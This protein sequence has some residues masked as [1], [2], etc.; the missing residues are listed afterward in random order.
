MTSNGL[1]RRR[2]LAVQMGDHAVNGGVVP[3]VALVTNIHPLQAIEIAQQ[4]C[5][6]G[7]DAG[8]A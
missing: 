2:G 7:Y 6:F 1:Q 3:V 8:V 5:R 4:C